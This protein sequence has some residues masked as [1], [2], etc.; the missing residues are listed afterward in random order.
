MGNYEAVKRW[1][2]NHPEEARKVGRDEQEKR[3]RRMGCPIRGRRKSKEK[4][5]VNP[6][7]IE[8]MANRDKIRKALRLK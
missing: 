1:R 3:R 4:K 6:L 5:G 8:A 2:L 7:I